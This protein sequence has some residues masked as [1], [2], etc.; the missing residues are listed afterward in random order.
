VTHIVIPK[1]KGN[2]DSCETLNEEE[3]FDVQDQYDLITLGWIHTHP[4]QTAFMSSVDLHTHCS[5]QIMMDEAVAIVCAP[6]YSQV[7]VYM[8]T[9]P[10]GLNYI[11]NCEQQGF[12]THPKEPPLYE[13]CKHVHFDSGVCIKLVDL[14]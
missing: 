3:I 8:L 12:H 7:G 14:R 9:E 13:D 6:R 5:Y 11:T 4:S 1:Q 10:H 2:P